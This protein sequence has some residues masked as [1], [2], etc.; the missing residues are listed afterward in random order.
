[1]AHFTI[2][3][4]YFQ[5]EYYVDSVL[6]QAAQNA[7]VERTALAILNYLDSKYIKNDVY[8]VLAQTKRYFRFQIS[9]GDNVRASIEELESI[10]GRMSAIGEG[11][12]IKRK[13]RAIHLLDSLPP[14]WK[15][16]VSSFRAY[17][18]FNNFVLD[19]IR[20]RILVEAERRK[21]ESN[22]ND[23]NAL[24]ATKSELEARK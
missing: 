19:S 8:S 4:S 20:N 15:A 7:N 12:F 13:F 14:S 21:N 18:D 10:A 24:Y 16:W 17:T 2:K 1:M 11:D 22:S 23:H 6:L 5:L 3:Q 9:E